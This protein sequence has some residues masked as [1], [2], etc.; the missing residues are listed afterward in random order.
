M[1]FRLEASTLQL[2]R[3][4]F[5]FFLMPVYWFALSQ[6]ETINKMNA[7]LIFLILHLLVYP[8]SNGYNSYMDR[9]TNSIGGI[10]KPMLPTK[11]LFIATVLMDIIAL[12]FSLFISKYFFF[13]VSAYTLA[14]RAYSNRTIRL[15]KYPILGFLIT[16]IFQGAVVFCMVYHGSD[17][18]KTLDIPYLPVIGSALLVGSFY[19]LTQIYQHKEDA[20]DGVKTISMLLG[21]N[22][23][24][25]FSAIV[26][27]LAVNILAFYFFSISSISSLYIILACGLPVLAYFFWWMLKVR[28]DKTAANFKNTMQMNIIASLCTNAGF[29]FI[30]MIEKF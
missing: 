3:I 6:V 8:S 16:I 1:K 5:S 14:S 22:G 15:K 11:Q 2:L 28:K 26:Y 4:K 9:D 24:F 23:T 17:V 12:L 21:L 7:L 25:I 10:E 19:P 29:I 20:E 18:N 13:F 30:L 27:F